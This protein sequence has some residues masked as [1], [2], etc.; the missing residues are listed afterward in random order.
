[1]SEKQS[2]KSQP[3]QSP[4]PNKLVIQLYRTYASK[5]S[6]TLW[7]WETARWYELVFCIL[8][9][10]GEPHVMA[11]TV[12]GLTNTMS[13]LGLLELDALAGLTPSEDE[14]ANSLLI[15]IDT[16]LQQVGFT[17]EKSRSAVTAICEAASSIQK[18]Y[19]GKVQNYFQKYGTYMLDQI[20]EDFGFSDFDD[21]PQA[22]AIWLQNTLNMP[23]PASNPL[24]DQACESLGVSYD[25]LVKAANQQDINVALL[26]DALRAYW[27][28]ESTSGESRTGTHKQG[29]TSGDKP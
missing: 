2:S 20:T 14:K 9:T 13:K 25:A 23:V 10:I 12:R 26:D 16:L 1:M 5:I 11:A 21:A 4:D 28:S 15:T 8:T 6:K 3:L 7:P 29:G 24:A 22:L 27:E 18:K 19:G 17:P